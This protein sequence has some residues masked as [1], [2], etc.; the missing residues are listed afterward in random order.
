MN[1]SAQKD[2]QDAKQL[3]NDAKT[4][5]NPSAKQALLNAADRLE[6]RGSKKANKIGR[7]RRKSTEAARR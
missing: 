1:T 2:F 5:Q 7:K 6:I 4:V 3:R